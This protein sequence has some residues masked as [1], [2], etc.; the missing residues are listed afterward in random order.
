MTV[1]VTTKHELAESGDETNERNGTCHKEKVSDTKYLR[2][3]N[4]QI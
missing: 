4:N 1:S 2:L 3:I